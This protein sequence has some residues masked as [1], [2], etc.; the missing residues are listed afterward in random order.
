MANLII[1][2]TTVDRSVIE[3]SIL[4]DW[5]NFIMSSIMFHYRT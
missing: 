4:F 2:G 5:P 1:M 3:R